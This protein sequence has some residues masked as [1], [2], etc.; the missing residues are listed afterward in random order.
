MTKLELYGI[1][2]VNCYI[3]EHDGECYIVDPGFQPDVIQKYV[4]ENNLKPLGILL[5]HGHFDHIGAV[6]CFDVPVYIHKDEVPLF[7]NAEKNGASTYD[8]DSE[9]DKA[10]L[11]LKHIADKDSIPLGNKHITVFHTPGHTSGG[12]CYLFD[13]DLFSGDTLFY[14]AVGRY[15]F[16]TGNK[17]ALLKSVR[18][19]I[20]TLPPETAVHPGHDRSTTIGFEKEN[21][22]FLH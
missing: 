11:K 5:T 22:P 16:P 19:L 6:N 17:D 13:N 15:D 10:A 8:S 20:D 21:N 1:M 2:D 14:L 7:M 18:V 9:F 3:I 4:K 12:V